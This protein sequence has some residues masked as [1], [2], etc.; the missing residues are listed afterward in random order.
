MSDR[1]DEI[2]RLILEERNRQFMLPGSEWDQRNTPND[3]VAIATHY[4]SEE[5]RRGGS[6][7]FKD[8][9]E[10]SLLKAAAVIIAA[11]EKT[12]MMYHLGELL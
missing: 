12:D 1:R 7:P 11:L 6:R 8:D 4:L 2:I 3:W 10:A 5:V 9:Y